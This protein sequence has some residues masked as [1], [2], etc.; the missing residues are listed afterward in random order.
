L[1]KKYPKILIK[2]YKPA[3]K[4]KG[5]WVVP[6]PL[7]LLNEFPPLLPP[8]ESFT[9]NFCLDFK[10]CCWCNCVLVI[11]WFWRFCWFWFDCCWTETTQLLFSIEFQKSRADWT[12]GADEGGDF[13]GDDFKEEDEDSTFNSPLEG[14]PQSTE[15]DF[16]LSLGKGVNGI[17]VTVDWTIG[18]WRRSRWKKFFN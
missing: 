7:L 1:T 4:A 13:R 2:K 14:F 3:T 16:A 5:D 18:N 12:N 15:E 6:L 8:L 10:N 9:A 11:G 17:R